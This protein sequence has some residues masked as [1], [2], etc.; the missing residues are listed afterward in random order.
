VALLS[1][2]YMEYTEFQRLKPVFESA[3]F[4]YQ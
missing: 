4:K 2:N 3:S 1:S